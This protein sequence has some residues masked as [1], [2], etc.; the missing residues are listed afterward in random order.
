MPLSSNHSWAVD[1]EMTQL[2]TQSSRLPSLSETSDSNY[3]KSGQTTT[4]EGTVSPRLPS[5][6]TPYT[7]SASPGPFSLLTN[8]LQMCGS[9]WTPS[10]LI[11]CKND[12]QTQE[13]VIFTIKFFGSINDTNWNQSKG[14][15]YRTDSG[16]A[17]KWCFQHPQRCATLSAS[18]CGSTE[19]VS[20]NSEGQQRFLSRA[21]T[22]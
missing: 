17:Q 5:L 22:P 4:S 21:F 9:S 18:M 10:G 12:S 13:S 20:S 11:I 19:R 3:N 1:L 16:R 2:K 6:Q 15:I 14:D 8:W 7:N